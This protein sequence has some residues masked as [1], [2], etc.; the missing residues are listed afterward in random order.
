VISPLSKHV[1]DGFVG[2]LGRL[3]TRHANRVWNYL[4]ARYRRLRTPKELRDADFYLWIENL[5]KCRD[6]YFLDP[7]N[8]RPTC[9][10]CGCNVEVKARWMSERC[11]L[12]EW[13]NTV[14]LRQRIQDLAS[15]YQS[16]NQSNAQSHQPP[17]QP[18]EQ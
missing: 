15:P 13:D 2:D 17:H 8:G 10:V 11:P 3:L 14:H 9:D 18:S 12:G 4:R 1:T 7:N 16:T 6:C 5:N